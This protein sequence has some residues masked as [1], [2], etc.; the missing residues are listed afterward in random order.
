MTAD[1]IKA[2]ERLKDLSASVEELQSVFDLR[3]KAD[4]RAIERWQEKTG[5]KYVWPDHADLTVWLLEQL[6]LA[7]NA[8]KKLP[9][10][11]FKPNGEGADAADFPDNASSFIEAMD[12][13]RELLTKQEE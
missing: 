8:L 9:L 4:M 10:D 13:A 12:L 3:Y 2:A 7:H 1:A 5:R 11:Q 6:D